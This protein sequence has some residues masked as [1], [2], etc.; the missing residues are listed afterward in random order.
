MADS[1][2]PYKTKLM[3]DRN[4]EGDW[5]IRVPSPV[6]KTLNLA[7]QSGGTSFAHNTTVTLWV[8]GGT[9]GEDASGTAI[10]LFV[11]T[12]LK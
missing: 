7:K 11:G 6:M 10:G 5:L 3:R 12:G 8:V 4:V 2:T 1:K 9:M